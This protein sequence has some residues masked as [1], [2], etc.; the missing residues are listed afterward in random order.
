MS[1]YRPGENLCGLP[2]CFET[3]WAFRDAVERMKHCEEIGKLADELG[4]SRGAVM[5]ALR[6]RD[7]I[8][9]RDFSE[10]CG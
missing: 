5:G 3:Q 9:S 10:T 4:V 7:F 8:P 2:P 1:V 6:T